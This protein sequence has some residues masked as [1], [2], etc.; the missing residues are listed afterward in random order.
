M[1]PMFM[2]GPSFIRHV[3]HL[4]EELEVNVKPFG[5]IAAECES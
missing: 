2:T 5:D 4:F 3:I 1:P